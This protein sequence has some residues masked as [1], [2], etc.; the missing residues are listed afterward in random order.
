M[1]DFD[2]EFVK[3]L[4]SKTN[5]ELEKEVLTE[6]MNLR[7]VVLGKNNLKPI[8]RI[9]DCFELVD[10]VTERTGL[11][12]TLETDVAG[13]ALETGEDF[14]SHLA[15]WKKDNKK[16]ASIDSHHREKAIIMSLLLAL[17]LEK[18]KK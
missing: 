9:K 1:N 3:Y 16:I 15:L 4:Y 2:K 17:R 7:D 14:Y 8:E 10:V 5:E 18:F 12:L 11:L 6:I 13:Y